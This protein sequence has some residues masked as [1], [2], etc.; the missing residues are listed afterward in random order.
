MVTSQKSQFLLEG[1]KDKGYTKMHDG[2]MLDGSTF[3][4]KFGIVIMGDLLP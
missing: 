1:I 4:C 2:K 3:K